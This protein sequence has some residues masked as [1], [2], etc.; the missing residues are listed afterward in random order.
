MF[1]SLTIGL[2]GI[3]VNAL[4][5]TSAWAYNTEYFTITR[6]STASSCKDVI[7]IEGTFSAPAVGN[8][9]N[10]LL[11]SDTD[12]CSNL[13]EPAQVNFEHNKKLLLAAFLAGKPVIASYSGTQGTGSTYASVLAVFVC[14]DGTSCG[15]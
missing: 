1:R 15:Q 3:V 8:V 9:T 12:S 2:L 7:I 6:L 5:T 10:Q 11:L 4:L 13:D 14:V